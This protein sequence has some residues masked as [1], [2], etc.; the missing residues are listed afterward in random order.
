MG[1]VVRV[2]FGDALA[3]GEAA[4]D[5]AAVR[6]MLTRAVRAT[7]RSQSVAAAEIS[8]T[9]LAD[10]EIADLNGM[11][12]GH[13]GATDVISFALYEAGE[14]PVG[15]VYLGFEEAARQAGMNGVPFAEELVRLTVHGMLHV[16][17]FDHPEG[18]ERLD[19]GMWRLQEEIVAELVRE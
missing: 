14:E 18:E 3:G 16:L 15:D 9:L 5:A 6:R 7:L 8:V 11:F 4:A 13:D 12:L 17:G 1:V 10:A 19:S 2:Q